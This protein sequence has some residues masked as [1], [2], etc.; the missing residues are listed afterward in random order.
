LLHCFF[1]TALACGAIA[2]RARK[3]ATDFEN[4]VTGNCTLTQT[5]METFT[6]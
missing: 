4:M 3:V 6:E 5:A 2:E 1:D